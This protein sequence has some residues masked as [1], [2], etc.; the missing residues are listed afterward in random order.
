MNGA[1][2]VQGFSFVVIILLKISINLGIV[3]AVV[4]V[5]QLFF[6]DKAATDIVTILYTI[7]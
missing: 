2:T 3:E 5:R 6:F 7:E 4:I 1:L